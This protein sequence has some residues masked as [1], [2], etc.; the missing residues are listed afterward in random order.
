LRR[1]TKSKKVGASLVDLDEVMQGAAWARLNGPGMGRF[2][3]LK[4][5]SSLRDGTD[6]VIADLENKLL[7]VCCGADKGLVQCGQS[8]EQVWMFGGMYSAVEGREHS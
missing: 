3:C 1:N 4:L 7:K 8:L 5:K 6:T 2:G